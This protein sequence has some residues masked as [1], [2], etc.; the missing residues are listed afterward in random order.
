MIDKNLINEILSVALEH[1]GDFSEIFL[2]DRNID[3]TTMTKGK[4]DKIVKGNIYGL[5]IRIFRGLD[6]VYAYTNVMTRENLLKVAKNA[7][8]SLKGNN[9]VKILNFNNETY[10][11]NSPVEIAFN[12]VKKNEIIDI[13]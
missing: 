10:N 11:N 3:N 4:V 13:M 8:M 6:S 9:K 2:E 5:G 1:G 7:A 12:E